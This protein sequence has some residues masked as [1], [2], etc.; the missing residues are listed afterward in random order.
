M[1]TY[2]TYSHPNSQMDKIIHTFIPDG[3]T[4]NN[5]FIETML[6]AT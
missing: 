1:Y 3:R 4:D 2:K 5:C 6:R